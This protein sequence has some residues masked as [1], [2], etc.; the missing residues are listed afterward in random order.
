MLDQTVAARDQQPEACAAVVDQLRSGTSS[1]AVAALY[2]NAI[3]IGLE[4]GV[5]MGS[6]VL[7]AQQTNTMGCPSPEYEQRRRPSYSSRRRPAERR[8]RR[9]ITPAHPSPVA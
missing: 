6:A 2:S 9:C 8:R 4:I 7:S 5:M 1:Q 3:E